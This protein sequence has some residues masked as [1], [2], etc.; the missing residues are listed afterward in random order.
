VIPRNRSCVPDRREIAVNDSSDH[1][2]KPRIAAQIVLHGAGYCDQLPGFE[3]LYRLAPEC[4]GT[5]GSSHQLGT[6]FQEL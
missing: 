3:Y 5:R 4:S 2:S 1:A 6:F